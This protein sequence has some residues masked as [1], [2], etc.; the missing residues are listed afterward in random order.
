MDLVVV[1]DKMSKMSKILYI[2]LLFFSVSVF[3]GDKSISPYSS[4]YKPP[5]NNSVSKYSA[6]YKAESSFN[7]NTRSGVTN[8]SVNRH[9]IIYSD[10]SYKQET[11]L[12]PSS[13]RIKEYNAYTNERREGIKTITSNGYSIKYDD[14]SIEKATITG[15]GQNSLSIRQKDNHGTIREGTKIN[16]STVF[17][18]GAIQ[19]EFFN[20]YNEQK[21][22]NETGKK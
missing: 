21:R 11:R 9:S 3:A 5:A 6:N 19:T 4:N 1:G 15:H 17:S 22:V 20:F 18:D 14:G 10:R 13:I 7:Q 2:L 12:T 8:N 16:N